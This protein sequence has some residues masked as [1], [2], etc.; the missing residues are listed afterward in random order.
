[1]IRVE[2]LNPLAAV[3]LARSDKRNALT[4]EMLD[5]LAGALERIPP[6]IKAVVMFG[7]GPAFCAGFDLKLCA[8]DPSG[9]TMRQLLTGLSR[10]VRAMRALEQPVIL[11][12]HGAAVAGGCALLGGADIVVAE[13][14]TKLGYPVANIGVSPAVSAP[15]LAAT[16]AD[17]PARARMLDP[18]LITAGEALRIGL[19]HEIADGPGATRERANDIARNLAAKPGIGVAATKALCNH[20]ARDRTD[21][22]LE[23]LSASLALTG[24]DEER[25]RL[26]AL[27]S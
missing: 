7:D 1:M 27:W 2:Y 12:I 15:F 20:L 24:S 16:I 25:D 8:A 4:P 11:G 14:A 17:G 9:E 3:T 13:R 10:C 26:A 6:E 18:Q 23:G 21:H 5:S 19:V 22:A